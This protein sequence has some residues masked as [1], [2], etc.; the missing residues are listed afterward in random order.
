[1]VEVFVSKLGHDG[2]KKT[3]VVVLQERDGVRVLPIWIGRPEAESI[4][5]HLHGVPRERPMTH[6]LVRSL[7]T[8]LDGELTRVSI[9]HVVEHT[10]HADMHISRNGEAFVVDARP[11]DAIAIALRLGAP[12]LAAEELLNEYEQLNASEE[13][14]GPEAVEHRSDAALAESS[15][16]AENLRRHLE[17]LKPEDFGKFSL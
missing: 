1:M 11:S 17:Q 5:A 8:A 15:S 4:A 12:I 10:Y 14:D 2:E 6:D 16:Y 13:L 9:T 3:F 7:I